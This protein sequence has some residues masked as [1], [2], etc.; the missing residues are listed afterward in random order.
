MILSNQ[1]KCNECGDEIY[2][3]HRH[4]YVECV[5]GSSMVDGGMAYLRRSGDYTEMS[6]VIPDK[7]YEDC[8]KALKR[9]EENDRDELGT[10]CA[11][12][13]AF[14]DNNMKLGE[15]DDYTRHN[16]EGNKKTNDGKFWSRLF[17]SK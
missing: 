10:I 2:S 17:Q 7:V 15:I 3:A 6:I 14:R 8:I 1:I 11:I 4:D 16:N 9:A 13:R 5:C 12:F